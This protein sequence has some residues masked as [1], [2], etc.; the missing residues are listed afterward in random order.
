[1]KP[2]E[3]ITQGDGIWSRIYKYR[4]EVSLFAAMLAFAIGCAVQW[5]LPDGDAYDLPV[6]AG[7][8][9]GLSALALCVISYTAWWLSV[10]LFAKENMDE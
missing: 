10:A 6:F 3:K 2:E 5:A 7:F 9:Y 4:I 1:M 8:V